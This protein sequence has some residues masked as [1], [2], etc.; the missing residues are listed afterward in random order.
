[1]G[2]IPVPETPIV[3]TPAPPP[4]LILTAASF[5]PIVVGRKTTSIVQVAPAATEVPQLCVSV[6]WFA[7]VPV[8]LMLVIGNTT[9]PVLVNVTESGELA[10]LS[11]WSPNVSVAGVTE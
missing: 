4:E 2:A 9:D 5:S 7:F 3:W 6:N 8:S 10:I 11:A 1:V